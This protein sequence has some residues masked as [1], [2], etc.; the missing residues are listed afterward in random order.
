MSDKNVSTSTWQCDVSIFSC[1]HLILSSLV[2]DS[3]IQ[4]KHFD[5]D[6][7]LRENIVFR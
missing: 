3:K 1:V 4:A 7:S 6:K 2:F 5:S